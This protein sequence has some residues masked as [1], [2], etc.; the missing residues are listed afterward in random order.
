MQIN[1]MCWVSFIPNQMVDF[2]WE[3]RLFGS[4]TIKASE[5]KN[6]RKPFNKYKS[7]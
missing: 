6:V 1:K 2:E 7:I 4:T 5:K 3:K